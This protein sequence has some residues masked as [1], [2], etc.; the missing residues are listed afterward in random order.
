MNP[1]DATELNMGVEPITISHVY[2][3]YGNL[4]IMGENFT[5]A[6]YVYVN[7]DKMNTELEQGRYLVVKDIA[8][9]IAPLSNVSALLH[10]VK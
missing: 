4:Y 5:D 6:S 2:E 1:F 3:R 7:G 9:F 8:P 10:F